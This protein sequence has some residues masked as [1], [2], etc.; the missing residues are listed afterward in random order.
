MKRNV[1]DIIWLLKMKQFVYFLDYIIRSQIFLELD[2]SDTLSSLSD[3]GEP[4][5]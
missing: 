4:F 3:C 5:H 1:E 2:E